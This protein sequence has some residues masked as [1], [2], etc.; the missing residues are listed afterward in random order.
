MKTN[1]KKIVRR[2]IT[3]IELIA[4]L[5]GIYEYLK[6]N[7]GMKYIIDNGAY[8]IGIIGAIGLLISYF[9]WRTKDK[10]E[11]I[12]ITKRIL[13]IIQQERYYEHQV[14]DVKI[15]NE[16]KKKVLEVL[17]K[18]MTISENEIIKLINKYFT[19]PIFP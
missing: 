15:M 13:D 5:I 7:I 16:D 18:E 14:M 2:L 6:N 3:G 8:I 12:D 10:N 1:H 17:K 9:Y 11:E 19:Y 4:S